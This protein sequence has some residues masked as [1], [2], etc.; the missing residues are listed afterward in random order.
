MA[1]RKRWPSGAASQLVGEGARNKGAGR[2]TCS[3]AVDPLAPSVMATL[4]RSP[5]GAT[6]K[7]SRPSPRQRG[8]LAPL[9]ETGTRSPIA[10]WPTPTAGLKLRDIQL[11]GA[12]FIGQ[13]RDPPPVWRKPRIELSRRAGEKRKRLAAG[14]KQPQVRSRR[15]ARSSHR[16]DSCH[17][18]SYSGTCCR[19]IREAR[20]AGH[21]R[22]RRSDTDR[23]GSPRR[24]AYVMRA[25]SAVQAGDS[26]TPGPR[27][28]RSMRYGD[29]V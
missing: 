24:D 16:S 6:K 7:S 19:R 11:D 9:E 4:M 23:N 26:F 15:C 5:F 14:R 13:I 3:V 8:M 1:N 29:N 2:P 25:L 20:S 27:A 22:W 21:L 28:S 12:R 18:T 10:D 17:G